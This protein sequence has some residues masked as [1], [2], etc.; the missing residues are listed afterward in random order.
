M[1]E[2]YPLD[3]FQAER[4][5]EESN[6]RFETTIELRPDVVRRRLARCALVGWEDGHLDGAASVADRIL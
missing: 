4:H 5:V 1:G 3:F 2:E 6:L